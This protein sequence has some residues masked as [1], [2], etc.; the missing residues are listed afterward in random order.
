MELNV[1]SD[2]NADT[3]VFS[4]DPSPPGPLFPSFPP[5]FPSYLPPSLRPSLLV[6]LLLSLLLSLTLTPP[7]PA[8]KVRISF[9]EGPF[10]GSESDD[11][12]SVCAEIKNGQI[13]VGSHIDVR[14]TTDT[15]AFPTDLYVAYSK[16][17][18]HCTII[19]IVVMLNICMPL[20][21]ELSL[22]A[23]SIV[24]YCF[25]CLIHTCTCICT[26]AARGVWSV[27]AHCN[28]LGFGEMVIR[29]FSHTRH[30]VCWLVEFCMDNVC[31]LSLCDVAMHFM[32]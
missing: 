23:I 32:G 4:K 25:V 29:K 8:S 22:L 11:N 26:H 2:N 30:L 13:G 10:R 24:D 21:T 20:P 3:L 27:Y 14:L 7:C 17:I 31:M 5:F 1:C 15:L 28:L 18:V 9:S 16:Y 12:V 19:G 6:S